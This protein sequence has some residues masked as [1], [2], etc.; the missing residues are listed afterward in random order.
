MFEIT[1]AE[2]ETPLEN[3]RSTRFVVG[4]CKP[5][6]YCYHTSVK[7]TLNEPGKDAYGAIVKETVIQGKRKH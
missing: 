3:R 1:E 5:T 4:A 2:S 6:R 7:K